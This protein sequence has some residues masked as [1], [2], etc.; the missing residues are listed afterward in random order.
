M[1]KMNDAKRRKKR[2]TINNT[3]KRNALQNRNRAHKWCEKD[4]T[5]ITKWNGKENQ[6]MNNRMKELMHGRK[7]NILII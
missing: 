5:H 2:N 4:E 6:N 3:N 1:K 7:V